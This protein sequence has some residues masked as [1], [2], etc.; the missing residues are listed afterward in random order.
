MNKIISDKQ[1]KKIRTANK[2]VLPI[3]LFFIFYS[4]QFFKIRFSARLLFTE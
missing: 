3:F 1:A 2:F 4:V